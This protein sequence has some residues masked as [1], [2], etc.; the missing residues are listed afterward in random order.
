VYTDD[1]LKAMKTRTPPLAVPSV[2]AIRRIGPFTRLTEKPIRAKTFKDEVDLTRPAA[3]AGKALWERERPKAEIDADG[4]AYPFAVY[5]YRVRAVN[6]LGVE[7]GPSPYALTIPGA[8]QSVQS[9][10]RGTSCDLRWAANAEKGL[11][12]Y[13]VYRLDGRWN[14]QPV[15]RLTAEPLDASA[16]TDKTAGKAARRYPHRRRGRAG[17]GGAA[18]GPSVVRARVEAVLQAVRRRMAPVTAASQGRSMWP[19]APALTAGRRPRR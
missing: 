3:I 13:R 10:E 17:P 8:V 15:S 6:A 19:T 12:G 9:R 16:F 11:K 1:Q 18:V 5:A 2:A 4:K 14:N 7:G